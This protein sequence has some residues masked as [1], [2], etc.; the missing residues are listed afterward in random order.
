M[1]DIYEAECPGCKKKI[2]MHLADYATGRDEVQVYCLE[3]ADKREVPV[4]SSNVL[5]RCDNGRLVLVVS[6]TPN[7]ATSKHG[8]HPNAS[9]P[10]YWDRDAGNWRRP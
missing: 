2:E 3:C 1:C 9:D 6:L 4:H 7:A 8:N 5:W 10:Y